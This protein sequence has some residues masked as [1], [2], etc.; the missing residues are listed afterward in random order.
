MQRTSNPINKIL[1]L[2]RGINE[3]V[4]LYSIVQI[5]RGNRKTLQTVLSDNYLRGELCE[6]CKKVVRAVAAG[7]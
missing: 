7:P 5:Y 3:E 4:A 1:S 6:G 2:C